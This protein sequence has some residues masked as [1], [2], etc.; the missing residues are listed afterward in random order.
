M[1]L[2]ANWIGEAIEK[3]HLSGHEAPGGGSQDILEPPQHER[4]SGP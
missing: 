1:H 2:F 3:E 4:L